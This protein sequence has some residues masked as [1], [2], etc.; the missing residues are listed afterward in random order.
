MKS[1]PTKM[2]TFMLL[3]SMLSFFTAC[4]DDEKDPTLSVSKYSITLKANGDGDK[5]INV[6]ATET[7]WNVTVTEGSSWLRVNKNGQLA[8]ISVDANT[9]TQPRHGKI[10]ITATANAN[11]NSEISVTQEAADYILVNGMEST[12]LQFSSNSGVNYKQTVKVSSNVSWTITGGIPDWLSVSPTNGSGDLN[13]EIYPK[14]D[15]DSDDKERTIQLVL[16]SGE[17]KAAIKISQDS[18]L[19]PD[20]YVKPT[21]VIKLYNGIAFDYAFGKTVSYYF[22]GYMEKDAVASMTDEE[23]ITVLETK[24]KR[25]TQSENE[26]AVFAGL[27]EGKAYMIYTVGYNKQGKRGILTKTE[28]IT[29]TKQTNEPMAWISDLTN[30]SNNWY[31]TVTKSATCS[32]Y[33]MISTEDYDFAIAE[34]VY[35]AWTIDYYIRQNKISEYVNGGDWRRTKTGSLIAVMT[36]GVDKN[37]NFADAIEWKGTSEI[38]SSRKIILKGSKEAKTDKNYPIIDLDKTTILK[39]K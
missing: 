4:G 9:T 7:D 23:I 2:G 26:V 32:S 24:F 31:W 38:Y 3:I 14:S 16:V 39:M 17:T 34:D 8:T 36:W 22:R 29:K 25:Y 27:D 6:S 11:L 12:A 1:L 35:Q 10:R 28:F 30:D 37:G 21:N 13:I 15:N 5:D 18:D 20:A 33:Y 19:D